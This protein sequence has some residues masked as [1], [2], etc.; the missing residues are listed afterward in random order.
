MGQLGVHLIPEDIKAMLK[1]A[2]VK[3]DGKIFYEGKIHVYVYIDIVCM[4]YNIRIFSADFV[5]IMFGQIVRPIP[6]DGAISKEHVRGI[7]CDI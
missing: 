4:L 2:G 7:L 3:M 1:T 6:K 5:K